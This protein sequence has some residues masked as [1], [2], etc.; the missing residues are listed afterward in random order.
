MRNKNK[1][2]PNS[3][4]ADPTAPAVI[5]KHLHRWFNQNRRA[6]PWRETT[7]P[8]RIWVSEVMLQQ[9]QVSTVLPYYDSFLS[10]F[11]DVFALA[12]APLEAVLKQWEGLG[13]YARARNLHRAAGTVVEDRQGEL[14]RTYDGFRALPGAGDYIASAVVSIAFNRPCAV[15][16]GNVKRVLARLLLIDRPVNRS[17][18]TAVLKSAA[19]TLLDPR[20]PGD[21]NQAMMELGALVCRP[22]RPDCAACPLTG[23]C[24]AFRAG[25]QLEFPRREK[26]KPVPHYYTAVGVIRKGKRMLITRRKPDGFLGGLW[27]FP[28]GKLEPGESAVD[29]CRREIREELNLSVKVG[30]HLMRVEHAYSHFKISIDVFNC[31]YKSGRVTLNGPEDFRWILQEE[32]EN[33]AFPGANRKFIPLLKKREK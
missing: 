1:T 19:E 26:K 17:S 4:I 21:F 14:P 6:L 9:T 8:Y 28:G 5:R 18:S 25:C 13:Y 31:R 30:D 24:Q 2:A 20:R 22:G 10:A 16:D 29:A 33:Y 11:P 15:V 27:E 3:P 32:I 23:C 12:S 7:D